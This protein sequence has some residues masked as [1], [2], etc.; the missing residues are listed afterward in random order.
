MKSNWDTYY[1]K[2]CYEAA[3]K[4]KDNSTKVGCY[5]VG[6]A[7]Q[8]I[9]MGFNGMP[10]GVNDN[11]KSRYERPKKYFFF[12]H[13]ERNAIYFAA[14]NGTSILP[15]CKL[16]VNS[17]PCADCARGI[18]QCGIKQ[19]IYHGLA[20][21]IFKK[22]PKWEESVNNTLEMFYEAGVKIKTI[23]DNLGCE[24]LIGGKTYEV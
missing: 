6:G 16:Y 18:I 2:L 23:H 9:S 17:I 3:S 20:D 7:N 10:I 5:I 11:D 4:S 19:V 12:E 15:D 14:R 13:A 8:V 1:L 24:A 22:N 21:E